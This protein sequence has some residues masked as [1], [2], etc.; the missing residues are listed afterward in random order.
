MQDR[1]G[2]LWAWPADVRIITTNGSVRRDGK[3]VLGRGCAREAV[4]RHPRLPSLLGERLQAEGNHLHTFS[5]ADLLGAPY[6]LWTFPVKH[7]WQERADLP[8]IAR[9][10]A[11]LDA[12]LRFGTRYVMPRPGCGNGQL[13]WRAVQPLLAVLPD[14][15]TVLHF[16][17]EGRD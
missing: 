16:A 15:V 6:E 4:E 11:E 14:T 5:R 13:A 3:A 2:D 10:V 9:S 12:R 8:L 17:W 7:H 1:P